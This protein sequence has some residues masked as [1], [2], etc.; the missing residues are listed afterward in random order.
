MDEKPPRV[1][2]AEFVE[3]RPPKA[4]DERIDWQAGLDALAYGVS[5]I[6]LMGLLGLGAWKLRDLISAGWF[7]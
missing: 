6:C 3:V 5:L 4:D 7:G 1:I 2:D